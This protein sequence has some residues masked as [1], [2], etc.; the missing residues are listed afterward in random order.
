[1]PGAAEVCWAARAGEG[2]VCYVPGLEVCVL[3]AWAGGALLCVLCAGAL[4]WW[5]MWVREGCGL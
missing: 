2:L 3:R 4:L 1:M 5:G